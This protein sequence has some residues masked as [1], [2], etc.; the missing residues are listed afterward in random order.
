MLRTGKQRILLF[1]ENQYRWGIGCGYD[2]NVESVGS[3]GVNMLNEPAQWVFHPITTEDKRSLSKDDLRVM[4][5]LH[6]MH[7]GL[8]CDWIMIHRDR[9]TDG[10]RWTVLRTPE[11]L[12]GCKNAAVRLCEAM[13]VRY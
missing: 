10:E 11:L 12:R 1:K 13:E 2:I 8:R 6:R 4:N 9:M 5:R 7:D 3:L